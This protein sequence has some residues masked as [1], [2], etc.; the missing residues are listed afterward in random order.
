MPSSAFH[1]FVASAVIVEIPCTLLGVIL[2]SDANPVLLTLTDANSGGGTAVI[3]KISIPASSTHS[4][5][6]SAPLA[7]S[8]GIQ[9]DLSADAFCTLVVQ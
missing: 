9:A 7:C 6:L 4:C 1:Y 5:M 2:T 8:R 3:C